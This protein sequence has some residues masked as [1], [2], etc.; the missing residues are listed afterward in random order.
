MPTYAAII[1]S[2]PSAVRR[3][4]TGSSHDP[5]R[6]PVGFTDL[7]LLKMHYVGF[8]GRAHTGQMVVHHRHARGLVGVFGE[9]YQARFPIRRMQLIDAYGGDDNRSMAADNTSAYNCRTVAGTSTFSDHAYGAA[10]DINPVENPHVTADSVLP[11][12]GR[13]FVDVDRSLEAD[14]PV[15]SS[16]RTTWSSA[17]SRGSA[18]S[19]AVSGTSPTTSTSTRLDPRNATVETGQASVAQRDRRG[20]S[21]APLIIKL[22]G[23]G[24]KDCRWTVGR[25]PRSSFHLRSSCHE[26]A[27]LSGSRRGTPSG[28][29]LHQPIP[30]MK[31]QM[32]SGE[33]RS[34]DPDTR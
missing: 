20:V 33:E 6:C 34:L 8:D 27:G 22:R 17:P 28:A 14:A 15:G 18:G 7:R 24:L 29:R 3:Q 25:S 31:A 16:S 1:E 5:V 19:G 26:R 12:G 32:M 21:H 23:Q 9:L 30:E 2:V 4:M 11:A 13:R 10:V